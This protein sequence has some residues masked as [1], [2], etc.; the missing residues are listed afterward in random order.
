LFYIYFIFCWFLVCRHFTFGQSVTRE[1]HIVCVLDVTMTEA[2]APDL[3]SLN[4]AQTS[5]RLHFGSG[6]LT[7]HA[8]FGGSK[9][10][11]YANALA[12]VGFGRVG[13]LVAPAPAILA[14]SVR[15]RCFTCLGGLHLAERRCRVAGRVM[16]LAQRCRSCCGSS[17]TLHVVLRK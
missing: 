13:T 12:K 1:H 16:E 15:R 4:A 6:Y 3:I 10:P 9:W 7:D 8:Q 11:H 2:R 14:P 5:P 17:A